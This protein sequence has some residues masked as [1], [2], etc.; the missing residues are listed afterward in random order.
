MTSKELSKL[1]DR[2]DECDENYYN[3]HTSLVSDSEYDQ[4]KVELSK[5]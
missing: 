3:K 4:L 5:E 1:I 2:I